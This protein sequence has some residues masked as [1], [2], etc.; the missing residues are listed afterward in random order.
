MRVWISR[1]YVADSLR[2]ISESAAGGERRYLT[3]SLYD[4]LH[5]Q[6]VDNRTAEQ[7]IDDVVKK[8]GIIIKD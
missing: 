8:T 6:P 2:V 5:P 1:Y 7:I 4:K 3:V